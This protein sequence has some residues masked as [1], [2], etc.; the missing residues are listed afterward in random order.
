MSRG[1]RPPLGGQGR[2][3]EEGVLGSW[4]CAATLSPVCS[5]AGHVEPE[6]REPLGGPGEGRGCP[7]PGIKQG[8]ECL[9]PADHC[10]DSVSCAGARRVAPLRLPPL[11]SAVV[12]ADPGSPEPV[13]TGWRLP[14]PCGLCR[15][16]RLCTDP[17]GGGGPGGKG[18]FP[19]SGSKQ[20]EEGQGQ[21]VSAG[22]VGSGLGLT[23]AARVPL[24]LSLPHR[25]M[26]AIGSWSPLAFSEM[27]GP[28]GCVAGL[29]RLGVTQTCGTPSLGAAGEA[30]GWGPGS[31]VAAVAVWEQ[32]HHGCRCGWDRPA[33]PLRVCVSACTRGLWLLFLST[34]RPTGPWYCVSEHVSP[35]PC[36]EWARWA[37]G[38]GWTALTSWA[39]CFV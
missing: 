26:T 29:G 2:E 27:H 11:A 28:W 3:S 24:V 4:R 1:W 17:W 20:E 36:V 25:Q 31:P 18:P 10:E 22:C 37:A 30:L 34:R 16:P 35:R 23:R 8:D 5:F 21:A 38:P 12:P 39:A 15:P 32:A 13:K 6:T 19:Q 9:L 7:P 14:G 33:C